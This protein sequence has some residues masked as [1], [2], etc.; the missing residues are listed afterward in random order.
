[1]KKARDRMTETIGTSAEIIVGHYYAVRTQDNDHGMIY[2]S[3]VDENDNG[4]VDLKTWN[5][6]LPSS[7]VIGLVPLP[8]P[9]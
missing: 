6:S 2:V 8:D 4:R 9:P 5:T 7:R 3:A 1:M